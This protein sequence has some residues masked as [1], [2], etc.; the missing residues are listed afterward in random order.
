MT[1]DAT[2]GK[3]TDDASQGGGTSQADLN[4]DGTQNTASGEPDRFQGKSREEI[5]KMYQEKEAHFDKKLEEVKGETSKEVETLRKDLQA[6]QSWYQQQ[7]QPAAPQ[8]TPTAPPADQSKLVDALLEN[9]VQTLNQIM[10]HREQGKAYQEAWSEGP[11]ALARA[12]KDRPDI[13]EGVDVNQLQQTIFGGIQSG[14]IHP[15]LAK[16]PEAW[17]MAA[18]QTRLVQSD[19]KFQPSPPTPTTPPQGDAPPAARQQVNDEQDESNDVE[20][21]PLTQDM[22]E[23]FGKTK[24]Q[25]AEQVAKWRKNPDPRMSMTETE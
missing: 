6:Y 12:K 7:Q 20:F 19:F 25:V 11:A 15:S 22:M 23:G 4:A 3:P 14:Q 2:S 13:F 9:P 18:G 21:D 1:E 5:L 17:M 10:D 16:K 8:P 24:A